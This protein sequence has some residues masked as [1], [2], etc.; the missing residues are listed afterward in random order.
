MASRLQS[1]GSGGADHWRVQFPGP[2]ATRKA[3]RNLSKSSPIVSR[4]DRRDVCL[5]PELSS[6]VRII[7]LAI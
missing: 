3:T 2:M 1:L 5:L 4:H 7:Q 6:S